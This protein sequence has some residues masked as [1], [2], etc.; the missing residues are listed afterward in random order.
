[1]EQFRERVGL[2]VQ[3]GVLGRAVAV[4]VLVE[5]RHRLNHL[6]QQFGVVGR[7]PVEPIA[8]CVLV[9]QGAEGGRQPVPQ[10]PAP[11]QVGVELGQVRAQ[12]HRRRLGIARV[13]Q[14][15]D[16]RQAQAGL[17]QRQRLV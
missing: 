16:L 9:V 8:V 17:P 4:D 5:H 13:K 6:H 14:R 12:G 15:L 7:R 11:V 1:M 10:Q 2:V 3:P